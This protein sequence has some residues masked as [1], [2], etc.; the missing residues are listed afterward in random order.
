[1][2]GGSYSLLHVA[3]ELLHFGNILAHH[4]VVG[5]RSRGGHLH[6]LALQL[7]SKAL[8]SQVHLLDSLVAK[9]LINLLA[10]VVGAVITRASNGCEFERKGELIVSFS[11]DFGFDR[12]ELELVL[13]RYATIFDSIGVTVSISRLSH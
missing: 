4:V 10:L 6:L 13:E 3:N 1:M 11:N 12:E 2:G 8:N 7:E 9:I 5:G